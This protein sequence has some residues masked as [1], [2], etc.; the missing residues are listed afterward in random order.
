LTLINQPHC[1]ARRRALAKL[2][3][4]A[5]LENNTPSTLLK[6][7]SEHPTHHPARIQSA[8]PLFV[9]ST[10]LLPEEVPWKIGAATKKSERATCAAC[11]GSLASFVSAWILFCL[12]SLAA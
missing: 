8:H 1:D 7:L 9:L 5:P 10:F 12:V 11:D 6:A 4:H 3:L 2:H